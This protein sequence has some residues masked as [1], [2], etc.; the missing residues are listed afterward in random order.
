MTSFSNQA[1]LISIITPC[2]NSENF[3]AECIDSVLG[4]SYTCWEMLIVDDCSSDDSYA[5][6]C[7]YAKKDVRVQVYKNSENQGAWYSRNFAIS[8]AKGRYIAFLDSDDVWLSQKLSVQVAFMKENNCDFSFSEYEWIDEKSATLNVKARIVKKLT[9]TRNL[10]HNWPG[11]LTVMYDASEIGLVQGMKKGNGDDF[12][13]F[14]NILKKAHNAMGI[15]IVLAKYR[16]HADSISY[17]RMKMIKEHFFVL[18]N[19]EKIPSMLSAFFVCTHI[20]I[21]LLFKQQNC[22]IHRIDDLTIYKNSKG[23]GKTF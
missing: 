21:M 1:D 12:S 18:H 16:R 5:I 7:E 20:I 14:L 10:F 22:N 8:K 6:A 3:I 19:I 2:Y 13:L 15:G 11:C 9:Y 23:G 17:N 4:Q